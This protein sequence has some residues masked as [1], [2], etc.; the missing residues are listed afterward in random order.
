MQPVVGWYTDK[1]PRPY[2]LPVGFDRQHAWHFRPCICP[3]IHNDPMLCVFH[4]IRLGHF[5]PGGL[6]CGVYGRRHK[7]RA[8]PVDLSGGRKLRPGDGA[9]DHRADPRSGNSALF[10]SRLSPRLLFCFSCI[11]RNGT[12]HVSAALPR[13]Q[14]NK[15]K[16]LKTRPSPNLLYL[17]FSHFC[18]F[19][20]YECD[21]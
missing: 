14:A 12:P 20:V 3:V 15:R 18:S 7:T 1:R 13:N 4:W 10:G 11:L 2:A 17:L 6:P 16:R 9:A 5:P 8:R 21:R 19:L